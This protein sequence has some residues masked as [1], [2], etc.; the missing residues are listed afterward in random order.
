VGFDAHLCH[1]MGGTLVPRN[2]HTLVVV[3]VARISGCANQLGLS[4]DDQIDHAKQLVV[5]MFD[6]LVDYRIIRTTGKGEA[7]DRPELAELEAILRTREADLVLV[8]GELSLATDL[9]QAQFEAVEEQD[10]TAVLILS[11]PELL[12]PHADPAGTKLIGVWRYG[13]WEVV[14]GEAR[15]GSGEPG[16]CTGPEADRGGGAGPGAG[17]EGQSSGGGGTGAVLRGVGLEGPRPLGPAAL[18]QNSTQHPRPGPHRQHQVAA[19]ADL[20]KAKPPHASASLGIFL[21]VAERRLFPAF[22][23]VFACPLRRS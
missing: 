17:A 23:V 7:L 2:G 18:R 4:L 8:K 6:G 21:A 5:E 3:I 15:G 11:P 13:L 9:S 19:A 14:P 20:G 1:G 12:S 10:H 22:F 16:L